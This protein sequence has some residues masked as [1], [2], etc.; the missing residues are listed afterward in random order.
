MIAIEN[1]RLFREQQEALERQT[2]MAEVLEIIAASPTDLQS[3]LDG[4]VERAAALLDAPEASFAHMVDGRTEVVAN[5]Q[6]TMT[7]EQ[8]W[9]P[10]GGGFAVAHIYGTGESLHLYGGDAAIEDEYPIEAETFRQVGIGAAVSVPARAT[11]PVLGVLSV[12]RPETN[13]FSNEQVHLL[14]AFARQAAIAMENARLFH[15]L[16][17]R[18]REI[19]EALERERAM[20]R[21][22]EVISSSPAAIQ[23]VFE[24]VVAEAGRLTGAQSTGVLLA[25]DGQLVPVASDGAPFEVPIARTTAA[26]RAF[27]DHAP[28]YIEDY[29]ADGDTALL[30]EYEGRYPKTVVAVPLVRQGVAIGVITQGSTDTVRPISPKQ[31]A[32]LET[33]ADQAVIAMENARLF[34][35]LEERNAELATSLERQTATSEIME[36]VGTSTADAEPVL[37]SIVEHAGELFQADA[38]VILRRE[39]D[40]VIAVAGYNRIIPWAATG[41]RFPQS[42]MPGSAR[43]LRKELRSG[44]SIRARNMSGSSLKADLLKG[45]TLLSR[46]DGTSRSWPCPS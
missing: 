28:Q 29:E 11:G 14:E 12:F 44:R 13:A 33:F 35:E 43:A 39:G 4:I 3:V 36:V 8:P 10:P 1:A 23:P 20:S 41:S 17:E 24:A 7:L 37:D 22:L 45:S 25:R 19:T 38:A 46:V 9:V 26:G 34:N 2:A 21:I 31:I 30:A 6:G 15:E 16:Q 18:N 27:L 32:M 42:D 40:E 5:R